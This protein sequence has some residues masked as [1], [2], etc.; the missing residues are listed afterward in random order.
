MV[1]LG[2]RRLIYIHIHKTGGETVEQSL[3]Q[4]E[5]PGD[6][7][8]DAEHPDAAQD[9]EQRLGLGKHSTALEVTHALGPDVWRTHFSWATVRNPYERMASFYSYLAASTEPELSLVGFPLDAAPE[10]QRAWV[11]SPDYS[12]TDQWAF[13]GVR[14]YLATRG[15][16]T[17][18]SDFLRHPLLP[19]DE[20][21]YLSQFSRLSNAAGDALLTNRVVKLES[22]SGLWPQLCLEMG[23]PPLPLLIRN[24]TPPRWKRSVEDLFASPADVELINAIHADDFR[25]FGYDVM[26]RRSAQSSHSGGPTGWPT[27]VADIGFSNQM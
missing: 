1:I 23:L 9:Y 7:I 24:E 27:D 13:A 16:R 12:M 22:L 14:A 3:A 19:T 17:P 20:P 18:F 26:G 2:S 21:A 5:T 8:L 11:E 4:I 6:V 10:V 15:S 25:W